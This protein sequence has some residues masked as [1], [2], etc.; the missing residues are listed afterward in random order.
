MIFPA[1]PPKPWVVLVS[2]AL[3]LGFILLIALGIDP[4]VPV[5]VAVIVILVLSAP[6]VISRIGTLGDPPGRDR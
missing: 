2:V 3:M 5:A 6:R 1:W 4:W